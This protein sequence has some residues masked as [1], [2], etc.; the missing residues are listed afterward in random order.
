MT[1]F[2]CKRKIIKQLFTY[3]TPENIVWIS[4]GT[5]RFMPDLKSIIE[6]RF[7]HSK[8]V[9]GEFIKGIDGK[10]RY[11]KPLRI[12]FYQ[13]IVSYIRE[14]APDVTLYFCMGDDEVWTKSL[15]FLPAEKGGLPQILDDSS[16]RHC[17]VL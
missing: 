14:F 16:S 4:L 5:F 15:G 17:G 8:T 3:I 7:A 13:K 12:R 11:F 9:Y 10:M 6:N 2:F 1:A